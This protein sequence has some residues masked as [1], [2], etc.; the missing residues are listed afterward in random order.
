MTLATGVELAVD[1][2]ARGLS[3]ALL[4]AAITLVFGLG[5]VLN[6]A[7]G[8]FAVIAVVVAAAVAGAVGSLAAGALAGLAAV[9][10]LGLAVDRTLLS[11]VYRSEGDERVLLG[12]FVTLGLG[13]ALD[14]VLFVYFPLSYS[15]AHGVPG[16]EAA[17]IGIRG[18]TLL[19]LVVAAPLLAGLFGFLGRT[20]LGTATRTVVYDETG[21]VLCGVNPRRIRTVVF[22]LFLLL[23]GVPRLLFAWATDVYVVGGFGFAVVASVLS[24]LYP[25]WKAAND[26]PVEALRG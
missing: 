3:F 12:I 1:G 24:G 25:A 19:T 20:R 10:V 9:V 26:P 23:A 13:I 14:G 21:A 4:G 8:S 15:L 17:G 5:S 2:L 16:V 22:L 11:S 7:L 6:L 18:S